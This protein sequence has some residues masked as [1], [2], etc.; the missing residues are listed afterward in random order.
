M[1]R[2]ASIQA[3]WMSVYLLLCY[4]LI[5]NYFP[6]VTIEIE[7]IIADRTA[8]QTNERNRRL[9]YYQGKYESEKQIE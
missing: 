3:S 5:F 9:R 2:I 8:D 7:S 1:I 4:L 6:P